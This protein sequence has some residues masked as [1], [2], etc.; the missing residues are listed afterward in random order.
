VLGTVKA[1]MLPGDPVWLGLIAPPSSAKTELLNS[2][3]RLPYV[4][5]AA[6]LTPAG[7]LSG[8][9]R[10][11][12]HT[13]AKGGLLRQIG[14]FGIMV[15]KDF[16]SIL[17]MRPDAKLEILGALREVYDGAWTRHLGT[18]GGRTLSWGGKMGMVFGA[19]GAMD[20]H[21]SVIGVMGDRFLFN[22]MVPD[23][24][25]F[26]WALKHVGTATQTMRKELAEA[27]AKLFAQPRREPRPLSDAE[28]ECINTIIIKAV[29]LRGAVERDRRTSELEYI[30]G[31]EGT[32]R[33]G[34]TLERLLAGLDALGVEREMAMK[35]VE[36][37]AM[38]SVPPLRRR[39]YEW[40]EKQKVYT[41]TGKIAEALGLPTNTVRRILENLVAYDLVTC[42]K[43]K[44]GE[45]DKWAVT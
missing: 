17:S 31:A 10:K 39:A 34:L 32:A 35:V 44:K 3:S 41:A 12:F 1:N 15:M 16:G 20:L 37:V 29:N 5:H 40:L 45:A 25:Q 21:H 13:G 28:A 18:E 27:V 14:A 6:T 19:T 33:I 2:V 30:H 24:G 11:Q 38:D 23:S 8:T 43:G 9:P 4:V 26:K 36:T 22:R 7:L 42:E